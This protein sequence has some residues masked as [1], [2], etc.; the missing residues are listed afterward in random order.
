VP[1]RRFVDRIVALAAASGIMHQLE[2][3]SEGGSDGAHIERGSYPIDWT[4]VGAPEQAPHSSHERVD[5]ADLAGMANLL[6]YLVNRLS[7]S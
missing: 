4:F 2:I 5:T 7:A 1:N 3:E 6:E